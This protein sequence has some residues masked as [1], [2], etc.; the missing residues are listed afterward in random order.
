[1]RKSF[2]RL[3]LISQPIV[4]S[5]SDQ[6]GSFGEVLAALSRV[7]DAREVFQPRPIKAQTVQCLLLRWVLV[8]GAVLPADDEAVGL[9][10][11][12]CYFLLSNVSKR[13]LS[14]MIQ[15]SS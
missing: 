4:R 6:H 10:A 14:F 1:M 5:L 13:I 2:L 12:G 11:E 8:V 7:D 9:E 15:G 3:L